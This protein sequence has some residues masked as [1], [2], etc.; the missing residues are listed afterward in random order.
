MGFFALV[1]ACTVVYVPGLLGPR[2]PTA[3]K[4]GPYE[5][6][7]PPA[8]GVDHRLPVR[9]SLV[10][11][12]F[13][14]FDVEIALLYPWV[15]WWPKLGYTGTAAKVTGLCELLVFLGFLGVGYVYVWRRGGLEWD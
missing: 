14:I 10:A 4:R 8:E 15:V 3:L 11:I 6:G 1:I 9:F 7:L 13:L 2:R 12:L 5:C